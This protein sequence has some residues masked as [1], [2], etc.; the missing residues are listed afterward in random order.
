MA[1]SRLN[2]ASLPVKKTDYVES[3]DKVNGLSLK[4]ITDYLLFAETQL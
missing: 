2:E 3:G 1:G 4:I